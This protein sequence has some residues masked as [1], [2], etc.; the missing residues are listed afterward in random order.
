ML[1]NSC[2]NIRY[3]VARYLYTT[4]NRLILSIDE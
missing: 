3:Q 1:H 4:L 2:D